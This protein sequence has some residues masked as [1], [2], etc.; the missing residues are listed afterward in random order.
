MHSRPAEQHKPRTKLTRSAADTDDFPADERTIPLNDSP[1]FNV[2]KKP[3]HSAN[4]W[5]FRTRF[6]DFF[7]PCL[8]SFL[9]VQRFASHCSKSHMCNLTPPVTVLR[10]SSASLPVPRR[11]CLRLCLGIFPEKDASLGHR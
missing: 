5:E 2:F 9:P 3:A 7:V 8:C 1:G 4:A 11:G 10:G 6:E